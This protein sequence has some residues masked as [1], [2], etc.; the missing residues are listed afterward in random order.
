MYLNESS[1]KCG[2]SNILIS[3]KRDNMLQNLKKK[4]FNFFKFKFFLITLRCLSLRLEKLFILIVS[5]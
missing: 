5:K 2:E 1:V 3:L 4:F